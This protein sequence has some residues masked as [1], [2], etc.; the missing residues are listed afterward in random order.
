MS[1]LITKPRHSFTPKASAAFSAT[2]CTAYDLG[3]D[4]GH[5]RQL[6]LVFL[7]H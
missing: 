6:D 5:V 7:N 1:T 4:P 3:A 2:I